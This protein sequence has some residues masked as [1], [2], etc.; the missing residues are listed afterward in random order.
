MSQ[1]HVKKKRE[2]EELDDLLKYPSM[3][4]RI[5]TQPVKSFGRIFSFIGVKL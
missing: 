2:G 4:K 1:E 3:T 5:F